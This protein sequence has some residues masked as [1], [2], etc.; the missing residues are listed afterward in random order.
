MAVRSYFSE[1][2]AASDILK[3]IKENRV[4][5]DCPGGSREMCLRFPPI[6]RAGLEVSES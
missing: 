2:E 4:A 3:I 6:S 5:A 1:L